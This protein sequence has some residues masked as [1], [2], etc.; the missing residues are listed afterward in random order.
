MKLVFAGV[1]LIFAGCQTMKN[2][3]TFEIDT[4]FFDIEATFYQDDKDTTT[5]EEINENGTTRKHW[6]WGDRQHIRDRAGSN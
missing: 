5:I 3:Q 2:A 6:N 1:L 4:M